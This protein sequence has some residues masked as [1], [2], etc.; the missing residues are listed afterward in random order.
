MLDRCRETLRGYGDRAAFVGSDL[1]QDWREAV[2]EGY[3]VVISMNAIHHLETDEKRAAYARCLDVVR[4]G[5]LLVLQERV[6][7]D[8]RF[9]PH[10]R[11]LWQVRAQDEGTEPH[12]LDADLTHAQWLE[13]ERAGGDKPETLELQL[14][15]LRAIGFDPVTCFQQLADRVVFGG[16]RPG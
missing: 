6:A 11:T 9:W 13:A 1:A 10:I 5:G 4:P 12:A 8:G 14:G 15:W 3:D 7:F 16:L 2:G